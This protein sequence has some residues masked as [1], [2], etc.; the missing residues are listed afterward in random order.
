MGAFGFLL[1]FLKKID[2][3]AVRV[4]YLVGNFISFRVLL[5]RPNQENSFLSDLK[6]LETAAKIPEKAS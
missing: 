5:G 6:A 1:V 2:L 4:G 3:R